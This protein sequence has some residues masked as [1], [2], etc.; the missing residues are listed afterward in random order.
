[1]NGPTIITG[2]V[3]GSGLTVGKHPAIPVTP[4]EI[5]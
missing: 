4:K 1:M 2:A 5:A 3:T